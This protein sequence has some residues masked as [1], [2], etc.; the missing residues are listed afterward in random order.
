MD[1]N[2]R[3]EKGQLRDIHADGRGEVVDRPERGWLAALDDFRNC[4]DKIWSPNR[5]TATGSDAE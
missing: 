1:C 2:R 3:I 4:F 5:A